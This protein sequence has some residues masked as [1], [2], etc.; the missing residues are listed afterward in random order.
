MAFN[1]VSAEVKNRIF[2]DR[3]KHAVNPYALKNEDA[4]R[5]TTNG[6]HDSLHRPTFV[7]DVERIMNNPFYNRYMDKTQVFSFVKNDDIS[8]RASH[9]QLVSRI[10]RDIGSVLNLN[11]DAIEAMALGHDIGHTPFGHEG[12]RLLSKLY[13]ERTGRFFN[14]NIQSGRVFYTLFKTNLTFQTLDGIICHNGEME[15]REYKPDTEGVSKETAFQVFKDKMEHCYVEEKGIKDLCPAT[16]EGCVVRISDIIAYLGKDRQDAKL[17]GL[18]VQK[19]PTE[20]EK[21]FHNELGRT[22]SEI[23]NN[24]S[25][26][27]IEN[28]YGKPYLAMDDV[29]YQGLKKAKNDNYENIYG[30]DPVKERYAKLVPMFEFFYE[31]FLKDLENHNTDSFIYKHHIEYLKSSNARINYYKSA[32]RPKVEWTYEEEEPNSIVCDYISS[33]TD[34]YFIDLYN[35]LKDEPKEKIIFTGY[36][37]NLT[38]VVIKP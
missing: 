24:I 3:E 16:L 23:I 37:D 18:D 21:L 12:E 29:I 25:V 32:D 19:M 1:E 22:N 36:F 6:D 17:L 7:R 10:A 26:S 8:R 14:H 20:A 38:D 35:L 31:K 34:D 27:I 4:I 2:E 30:S 5:E 28:S 13:N 33:M 15:A 9:V 11:T